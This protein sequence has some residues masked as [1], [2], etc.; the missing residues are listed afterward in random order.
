MQSLK[1]LSV[2]F[3]RENWFVILVVGGLV[4]GFVAL[5]TQ[6]S[7]S[8]SVDEEDAVLQAGEPTLVEFYT[9]T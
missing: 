4:L 6:A 3:L 9:N 5:R 7:A 8:G 1:R 2:H